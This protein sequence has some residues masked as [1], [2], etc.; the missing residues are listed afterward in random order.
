MPRIAP[1]AG[2][3]L[4]LCPSLHAQDPA[5]ASWIWGGPDDA[6]DRPN[7]ERCLLVR[8]I[9]LEG[10]VRSAPCVVSADNSF[11]LTVNGTRA[12]KGGDWTRGVRVDLAPHLVAGTNTFEVEAANGGGP[13]G[14]ILAVCLA[15]RPED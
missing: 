9:E 12:A 11:V 13:A 6:L 4:V 1:L 7:G 2:L 3:A 5:A 8:S 10:P 14:L 15:R